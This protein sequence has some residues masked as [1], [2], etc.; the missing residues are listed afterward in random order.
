[1]PRKRKDVRGQ[2]RWGPPASAEAPLCACG[3]G[4]PVTTRKGRVWSTFLKNHHRRRPDRDY[5]RFEHLAQY[6]ITRGTY[7]AM[8]RGQGGACALCG[9]KEPGEG[10]S[11][12]CVDHD[13]R[14]GAVRGLLC[15]RCN[16]GLGC[17]DDDAKLLTRAAAY[18]REGA[19]FA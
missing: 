3:C 6:G 16:K 2:H 10:R 4:L 14:T 12:F 15:A 17:F 19:T 11:L 1:M 13:H 5:R 7:E 8:L 18:V 9:K